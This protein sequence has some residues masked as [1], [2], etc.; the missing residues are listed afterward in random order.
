MLTHLNL[1]AKEPSI[2][3]A[4][5]LHSSAAFSGAMTAEQTRTDLPDCPVTTAADRDGVAWSQPTVLGA[6]CD[7]M[8]MCLA[9]LGFS[10]P[11]M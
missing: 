2:Y 9:S 1:T 11:D 4:P 6:S 10:F 3:H 5:T 8:E 7:D